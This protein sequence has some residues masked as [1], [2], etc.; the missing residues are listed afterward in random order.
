MKLFTDEMGKNIF[1]FPIREMEV[2][3]E[4]KVVRAE[5]HPSKPNPCNQLKEK[6]RRSYY[7]K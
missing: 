2:L 1:V 7:G 3:S 5:V 4:K 6:I